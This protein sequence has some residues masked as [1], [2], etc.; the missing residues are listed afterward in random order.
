MEGGGTSGSAVFKALDRKRRAIEGVD[1][2]IL[3]LLGRRMEL[4]RSI[5]R[6]KSRHRIPL[7]NFEVEAQVERR[8]TG[9]AE[10]SGQGGTMG[11]NL[12]RFLIG[13]SLEAQAPFLDAA[14]AGERLRILVVGG[15]GGMGR[16]M[17][18]FLNGQGHAVRV[19]DP[20]PGKTPHRRVRTPGPSVKWADLVLVSVPMDACGSV[21]RDLA[22][23]K[24]R[25]VV[26][27][28][29]SLKTHL[30]PVLEDLRRR[31]VRTASFHPMFGPSAATL[32][33]K[34]VLFCRHGRPEDVA[35]VRG[36]FESTSAL[37]LDV[38]LAEH[39]L[40]MARVLGLV[41]LA[42]LALARALLKSGTPFRRLREAEG[43]TFHRQVATTE[44]VVSENPALYFQI[45]KRNPLSE[46]VARDLG[47]ALDEIRRCVRTG[48]GG[49][50]EALMADCRRYFEGEAV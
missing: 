10:E 49:A 36:L 24:P 4:A 34:K 45:Q 15:A 28:L 13:A 48:D 37:L 32:S 46:E 30:V 31:G 39:D 19:Y 20:G 2:E 25:G 11:K 50:F 26:A 38:D 41:H 16:W 21:L 14:Y 35:L 6:I 12:A 47:E 44:E 3:S 7:R 33:D 27:E 29:C 9:L 22:D 23:L 1:A 43:V 40:L 17:G 18:R 5:G 8:L 42:N